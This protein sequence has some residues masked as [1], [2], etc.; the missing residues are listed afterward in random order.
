MITFS[1]CEKNE[2]ADIDDPSFS[3]RAFGGGDCDDGNDGSSD[4]GEDITDDEDDAEDDGDITD[5]EDDAEDD[6]SRRVQTRPSNRQ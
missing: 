2:F 3:E 4:D 6:A 1:S 5:D